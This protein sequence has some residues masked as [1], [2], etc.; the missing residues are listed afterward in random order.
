LA[1]L[2]N[3][4]SAVFPHSNA[5]A[6]QYGNGILAKI[7][8]SQSPQRLIASWWK[9]RVPWGPKKAVTCGPPDRSGKWKWKPHPANAIAPLAISGPCN[10]WKQKVPGPWRKCQ[11]RS[12]R[13]SPYVWMPPLPNHLQVWICCGGARV[14]R[15]GEGRRAGGRHPCSGISHVPHTRPSPAQ[16]PSRNSGLNNTREM[17]NETNSV[18][19]SGSFACRCLQLAAMGA[20]ISATPHSN[21]LSEIPAEIS[22]SRGWKKP[23]PWETLH[24]RPGK[25]DLPGPPCSPQAIPRLP[26]PYNTQVHEL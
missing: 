7:Q 13:L 3:K 2:C 5:H 25:P 8:P 1:G 17:P 4:K 22:L 23:V 19:F 6:G 9:T 15:R 11:F 10:C 12:H 26:I 21:R 16:A 18:V 14:A 20:R 24:A